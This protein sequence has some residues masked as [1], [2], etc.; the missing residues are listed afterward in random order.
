AHFA[1]THRGALRKGETLVVTGAA[2][3]VGMAAVQV[4]KL[5]GARVIAAASSATRLAIA[6]QGGAD[7]TTDYSREDLN[8]RIQALTGGAGAD[9]VLDTVGGD[10]FDGCVR[11]MNWEGRLLVVGFASGRIPQVPA[12]L[13]LVKNYSVI[14][15]VFGAQTERDPRGSK[16]RLAGLLDRYAEGLLKPP[17]AQTF[18][19]A[20]ATEA[21]QHLASHSATGKLVL[22]VDQ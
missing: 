5:L 7:E 6:R 11:A 21:L 9:V 19:L 3:G 18:P 17:P 20:R 4:G 10:V 12:N 2:G 1:L 8:A 13:I 14:G 15:V 22:V 16:R